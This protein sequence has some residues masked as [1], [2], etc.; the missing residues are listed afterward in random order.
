[1]Q[2]FGIEG[3]MAAPLPRVNYVEKP[4]IS[5]VVNHEPHRCVA[6]TKTGNRCKKAIQKPSP[7]CDLHRKIHEKSHRV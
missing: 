7:Y 5:Q 2:P 4:Q 1:M 6:T 3:R